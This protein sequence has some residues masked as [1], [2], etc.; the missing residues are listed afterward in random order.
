M[1]RSRRTIYTTAEL[2][3]GVKSFQHRHGIDG[4]GKLTPQTIKVMNVP[5]TERVMQLQD[6]LERWRWLPDP[7]VNLA[8]MVNLPEFVLRGY[9][10]DHKLGLHHEG[11]GG[12]GDGRA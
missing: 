4:D 9:T 10:P 2:S 5:L 7:Y 1:P 8:L 6:S 11:G 12:Q 3:K